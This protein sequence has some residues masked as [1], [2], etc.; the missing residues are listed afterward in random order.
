M[1]KGEK[2]YV[3]FPLGAKRFAF[4]A[5][6]VTELAKPGRLQS[7]PHRTP[8]L[9]GVLARRGRIIPVCDVA[10][11]LIGL[12]APA[13]RFYLIATRQ[14]ARRREWTAIPVTG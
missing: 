4:P 1:T 8:M 11:A 12:D 9:T 14:C 7:F 2:S 13:R 3:L 6:I 10:P 5:E